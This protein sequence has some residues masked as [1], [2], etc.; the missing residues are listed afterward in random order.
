VKILTFTFGFAKGKLLECESL[1]FGVQKH[2]FRE[3]KGYLSQVKMGTFRTILWSFWRKEKYP[4]ICKPR[5]PLSI[6]DLLSGLITRVFETDGGVGGFQM[7]IFG[8]VV[9]KNDE[10][11]R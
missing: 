1:P 7:L 11:K 8:T 2:T 4:K 9:K 5:F 6:N 10:N 3:V